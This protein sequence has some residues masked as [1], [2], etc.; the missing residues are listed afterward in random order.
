MLEMCKVVKVKTTMVVYN[1]RCLAEY[2]CTYR[3]TRMTFL[4]WEKLRNISQKI[5]P[6]T[7]ALPFFLIKI[8][9]MD[10]RS[11]KFYYDILFFALFNVYE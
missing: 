2:F 6:I 7:K 3:K 8:F 1:I 10:Y 4:V 11:G 9:L 5:L